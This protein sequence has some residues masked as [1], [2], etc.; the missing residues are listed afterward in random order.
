MKLYQPGKLQNQANVFRFKFLTKSMLKESFFK[1]FYFAKY[2]ALSFV[3]FGNLFIHPI[4]S[5]NQ[6]AII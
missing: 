6:F 4:F 5:S 1:S 2:D 3:P